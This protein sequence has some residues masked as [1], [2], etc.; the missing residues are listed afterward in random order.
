[1]TLALLAFLGGVL[2][3]LSPCILPV[4]PFVFARAEQP[5]LRSGLP[6]LAGMAA[7]FAGVATLAAVGGAWAVRVNQYGRVAAL[8]L[9]AAFA[10]TLLSRHLAEWLARPFIRLGNRLSRSGTGEGSG[11]G[12]WNSL[13]LGVATGLL[14]APCAGPIL[15]L[16]LTGAA[17]SGPNAQTTLLLFALT[18]SPS[19]GAMSGGNAMAG[20]N[21]MMMMM[22]KAPSSVPPIEG[23]FPSLNGASL[24]LNSA[25][26]TPEALRGKVVVID[27][28]T[29]SCIN[30]LRSLP[31]VK[32]WYA[33]YKDLGLVVIGVHAP[34]F[35][36]EKNE[37]NVRRAVK[38]LGISYP[39]ALDNNYA[40]WQAFNNQFWPA[41]YFIDAM[42]RTRGHHFGEGEY[43][44]SEQIIR[45]L[46]T[47][48]GHTDL[49]VPASGQLQA[50]G[51]E[52]A[53]DEAHIQSPETYIG[54][55]RAEHFSS[56]GGA[57]PDQSKAYTVPAHLELNQ[58]ALSGQWT[59]A[60]DQA[61]LDNAPGGISFR[62]SARDVHLV[63][64]PAADGKPIRFHVEL[65]GAPPGPN[66]GVDTRADGIGTVT[67][68]RLYQLI[69]QSQQVGQHTVTIQFLDRGVRAYSFTFG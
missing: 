34:E 24:W 65:D 23:V 8:V 61:V 53:A 22:S 25:P 30:C 54:Y 14:W 12:L 13:L 20:G 66:H 60:K 26:L 21:T 68:E 45:Q 39:V 19:G 32:A 1:M 6:L 36:F 29:Y 9:L 46:L 11:A 41:H 50:T 40:I 57:T 49:P 15:G 38:D 35:A 43:E 2:T 56:P 31:Y 67:E 63:M 42:G 64:G 27:F 17:I 51:V 48:A 62:F 52:A 4:L 18:G 55:E 58:W 69:R 44:A 5:F 16:V 47:E 37:A 59:I 7:S 33:K 3:I 10:A 28:W